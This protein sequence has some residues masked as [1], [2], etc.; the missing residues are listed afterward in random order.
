[1]EGKGLAK[2]AGFVVGFVRHIAIS[3]WVIVCLLSFV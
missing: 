1:V 3:V 2:R